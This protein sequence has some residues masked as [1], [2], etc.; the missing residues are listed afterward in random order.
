MELI[1]KEKDLTS[2]LKVILDLNIRKI[3]VLIVYVKGIV[4]ACMVLLCV[5]YYHVTKLPCH[6]FSYHDNDVIKVKI[7]TL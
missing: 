6:N 5:P 3:P 7:V 2:D 4:Y 1:W